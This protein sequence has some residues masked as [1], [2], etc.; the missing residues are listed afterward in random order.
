[1]ALKLIGA[2]LSP[3]VRKV[4]VVLAEKGLSYD[5]DPLVPFG[6]SDE[7]K[8]LHP[9]GKIPT[10]VD[11]DR[12]VPDSSAI[13]VYLER[14]EPQPALY[15][16][17]AYEHA[18]AVWLEEF[19][20]SA[21]VLGGAAFFQERVLAPM[22][23]KRPADEARVEK[24]ASEMLPPLFDYLERE[25]GERDYAVGPRFSIADVALGTQFVNYHL[26]GGAVDEERWPRLAA[27]VARVH[28][29]PSFEKLIEEDHGFVKKAMAG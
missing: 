27:Y 23:F 4:R 19:A 13:C 11:G 8:R 16:D 10:L 20:D 24:A 18:R 3:F 6:V 14:I 17:D 12:V 2:S 21:L 7:Y 9:L 28:A 25:I 26:G 15:P 5:H 1:M 29:R 22:F